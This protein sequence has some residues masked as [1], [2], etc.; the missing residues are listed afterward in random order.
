MT[1]R[2]EL[3]IIKYTELYINLTKIIK[4][5]DFFPNIKDVD[6]LDLIFLLNFTFKDTTNENFKKTIDYLLDIYSIKLNDIELNK[7]YPLLFDFIF[8]Y[9]ALK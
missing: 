6:F 7:V 5:N 9:K 2:K 8:W 4:N 1:T 3:F